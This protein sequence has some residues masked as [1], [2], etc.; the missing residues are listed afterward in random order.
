MKYLGRFLAVLMAL[1]FVTALPC[2]AWTLSAGQMLLKAETYK[3]ALAHQNAYAELIPAL[4]PALAESRQDPDTPSE[5]LNFLNLIANLDAE[6]WRRISAELIPAAWLQTQVETNLDAFFAWLN[7]ETPILD[8][9]FD[10]TSLRQRLSGE[11]GQRA[12]NLILQSWSPCT[13]EQIDILLNFDAASGDEFPFCQPPGQYMAVTSAALSQT[14]REQ[15]RNL[16]DVYPP[17]DWLQNPRTR[18]RL[19]ELKQAVRFSQ[20]AMV[21]LCL[22]PIALLSLVVFFTVR[23][24]KSF[25]Y[26]SGTLLITAGV[27]TLL[28][29]PLLL[30]P[31]ILPEALTPLLSGTNT[32]GRELAQGPGA[33]YLEQMM[34]GI[35]RSIVSELARPVLVIGAVMI[36]LGFV[37]LVIAALIRSNG[38]KPATD[39]SPVSAGA[40]P[41]PTEPLTPTGQV[42]SK[43]EAT[44]EERPGESHPTHNDPHPPE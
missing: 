43:G 14:L 33:T 6:D 11:P 32:P 38:E 12:V 31:F 42:T 40:T 36:G 26:W 1:L 5:A 23:S 13:P 18:T 4:L 28:P 20:L 24:L 3:S 8:I 37:A 30:S 34:Y 10:T 2:A 9:R 25:G 29:L 35:T 15:A 21:E 17:P 44:D 27:F 19:Q 16:P 39:R 22:L 41:T 7:D